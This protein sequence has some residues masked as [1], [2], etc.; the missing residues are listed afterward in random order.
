[1]ATGPFRIALPKPAT[2]VVT[3]DPVLNALTSLAALNAVERLGEVDAW[4]KQ[5]ATQ[6]TTEERHTN[7]LVFEELGEVLTPRREWP[8]FPAYLADLQA[9]PPVALRDQMLRALTQPLP[10][11]DEPP[12]REALLADEA[13]FAERVNRRYPADPIDRTLQSAVHRLLNDPPALHDL[14]V[15]H[16]TQMWERYLAAEWQKKR[17]FLNRMAWFF[18]NRRQFA[19]APP[20]EAIRA[21]IGR[22]LPAAI[23]SQL[24]GVERVVF[25]L[26]PHVGP[27]ASR[28]GDATTIWVFVRGRVEYLPVREA[29]IKRVELVGP[30]NALAD[31]TR[32]RI[33]ELLAQN[34]ELLAQELLAQ[35]DL[36]QSSVSRHL[37]QLAATGFVEERRGEGANKSYRLIPAR[38]DWCFEA[39]KQLLAEEPR[40]PEPDVR[41]E[42]PPELRRFLDKQG[43][44][45]FWPA[46]RKDQTV[47]LG[48][49][50]SKL[51][52]GRDYTEREVNDVLNAWHTFGDHAT[53]RRDLY[54]LGLL[55]RS[56]DGRRYWRTE[57]ELSS[58]VHG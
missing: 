56:R 30:F 50:I 35:L 41:E 33:L 23:A 32:L 24:E 4:V 12:A 55:D 42:Y 9:Q 21:F 51:E 39:L 26:S 3:D 34:E 13:L 7:R 52:T 29:P 37:K 45:S 15:G 38:L 28:F 25:V 14:I 49:L 2:L 1:M 5:T 46:K 8:D 16:L 43:R 6:L 44:V 31:G 18:N 40:A 57:A 48:Y 22:D 10:G 20:A 47:I 19:P 27:L 17:P 54:D 53:I 36:S 11:E 58:N